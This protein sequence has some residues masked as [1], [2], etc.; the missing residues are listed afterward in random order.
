MTDSSNGVPDHMDDA[1]GPPNSMPDPGGDRDEGGIP[2][3]QSRL[4]KD[5]VNHPVEGDAGGGATR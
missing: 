5:K 2:A 1:D 3:G 4:G